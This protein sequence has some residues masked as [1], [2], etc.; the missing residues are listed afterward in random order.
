MPKLLLLCC[1]VL[2]GLISRAQYPG[3]TLMVH[4]DDFKARFAGA[5]AHLQSLACDFNQ[6]KNLSVLAEK[7]NSRGK[8]YFRKESNVRMEYIQPFQYLMILT[9]SHIYIKDGQKE[10]S[11]STKSSKLFAQINQ[12]VIDCV[13]GTAINN[14]DFGVRLFEGTSTY[15][16]ELTPL[17]KSMKDLFKTISVT[18]D[19]KDFTASKINMLEPG[20][21]NTLITFSHKE[22]NTPLSDALFTL[23]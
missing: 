5:S 2:P 6:E 19:K 18:L 21:D 14:P 1:L 9:G 13:K 22:L 8:F 17:A 7:I 20:G 4:T 16:I 11:V 12:L 3:Y 23:H 15:L 10:N